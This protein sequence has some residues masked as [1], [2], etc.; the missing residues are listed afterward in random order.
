MQ[1]LHRKCKREK[2]LQNH[3]D[4]P[5]TAFKQPHSTIQLKYLI[6]FFSPIA[7]QDKQVFNWCA[8]LCYYFVNGN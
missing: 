6:L 1:N 3:F 2:L 5:F 7:F 8:V 4:F